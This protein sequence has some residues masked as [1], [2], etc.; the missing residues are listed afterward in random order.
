[1]LI[2]ALAV[3]CPAVA[4]DCDSGP[5]EILDGG[6]AGLLAPC[7]DTA[8][9]AEALARMLTDADL[10]Q[11]TRRAGQTRVEMFDTKVVVEAYC[12][13]LQQIPSA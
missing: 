11:Q 9:L 13:W 5:F 8:R 4:T 10:S 2:E 1:M 7:G 6:A 3:G 12:R